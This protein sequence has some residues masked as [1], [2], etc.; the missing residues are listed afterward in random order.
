MTAIRPIRYLRHDEIDKL[1]WDQCLREAFNG[2]LYGWSWYLDIVHK[3]WEALVEGDYERVFPLTGNTRLGVSY[4]FQPFFAQQLGIYSR[5]ILTQ[6]VVVR[7][8]H[9]IPPHYKLVEIRLNKHNKVPAEGYGLSTHTNIELDLIHTYDRI[10]RNY[11]TNTK[12]NLKKAIEAGLSISKNVRPEQIVALFRENRGRTISHWNDR[13]YRRFL[14]LA[15]TAMHRGQAISVGVYDKTNQ[16][17]SGALFVKSNGKIVFLFS[18]TSLAG[19]EV[20]A[21]TYLIDSVIREHAPGQFILDFEGSDQPGLARF[22]LGFG[23]Q[24]TTYPGIHLNR[25]PWY[26]RWPVKAVKR[27]REII[28]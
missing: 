26:L 12:R 22:Y 24:T 10:Y 7:F 27:F 6:E 16:L 20:N 19:K 15:Y 4:L 1:K 21:L 13:E 2:N 11:S 9:A 17:L 8:L 18:G 25:L 23:G 3:N 14:Q 5:H 28:R